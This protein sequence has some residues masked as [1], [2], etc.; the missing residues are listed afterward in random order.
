MKRGISMPKK[1][2]KSRN[3]DIY[4][5]RIRKAGSHGDK[6]KELSRTACRKFG[7]ADWR[8]AYV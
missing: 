3:L 5:V 2:P 8:D 1:Y 7:R 6:K 4:Y